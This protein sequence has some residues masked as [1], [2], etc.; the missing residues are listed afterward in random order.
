MPS[1]ASSTAV[2]WPFARRRRVRT[3]DRRRLPGC[4]SRWSAWRETPRCCDAVRT[5]WASLWS[6][7][8][9]LY[10][11]E[12][13]LDPRQSRMA[14]LVQEVEVEDCSGVAFGRDPRD[15]EADCAI[16]EAVPGQ[17]ALLVD[18]SVDPDRWTLQRSSGAVIQ[19]R[20]GHRGEDTSASRCWIR[21][22]WRPCWTR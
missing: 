7:A 2:P 3:H 13:A 11:R 19:W 21:E 4:M 22:I 15:P 16:I 14:V 10:R 8:A 6:D 12:L 1:T 18:G 9:L 5:V 17:C 20:P